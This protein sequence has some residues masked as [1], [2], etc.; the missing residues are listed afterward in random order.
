VNTYLLS[1]SDIWIN[2]AYLYG[3]ATAHAV[4]ASRNGDV[5]INS[6]TINFHGIIYAPN[7]RV[8]ISGS[9]TI[10]GRIFAQEIVIVSDTLT[11]IAGDSDISHLGFIAP[12]SDEP[13]VTTTPTTSTTEPTEPTSP[14]TSPT[15]TPTTLET[16]PTSTTDDIPAE[17]TD[18][19]YEYDS[20]GRLIRVVFD[21]ENYIKYEYD[22]NGNITR[23]TRV[24]DGIAQ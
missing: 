22:V 2:S 23:V 7:G 21:D 9:G 11:I 17:F 4:I 19:E 15:T 12:D 18:V 8:T 20:L 1:E 14:V 24:V 10:N 3:G 6:D 5:V 16:T 13:P